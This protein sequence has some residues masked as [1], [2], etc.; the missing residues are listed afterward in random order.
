MAGMLV[1]CEGGC[2]DYAL[3]LPYVLFPYTEASLIARA[4]QFYYP[5]FI[6]WAVWSQ[7]APHMSHS[8]YSASTV[9]PDVQEG[10]S[11][12]LDEVQQQLSYAG[13]RISISK[14]VDFFSR[15]IWDL[16]SPDSVNPSHS[17]MVSE[18]ETE[19]LRRRACITSIGKSNKV[20]QHPL[21]ASR[22]G[23][24]RI[25]PR[26]IRGNADCKTRDR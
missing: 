11:L 7:A 10:W 25:L 16:Y 4:M 20:P 18:L 19:W 15:S 14:L 22:L 13:I 23:S 17:G 8:N 3:G 6:L 26:T 2:P 1:R 5:P 9:P 21:R 12:V 24:L